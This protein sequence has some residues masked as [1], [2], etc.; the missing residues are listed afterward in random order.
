MTVFSSSRTAVGETGQV[1]IVFKGGAPKQGASQRRV[2]TPLVPLLWEE[3]VPG[4]ERRGENRS[5]WA[6]MGAGGGLPRSTPW[7][8]ARLPG[9]TCL[10]PEPSL[11]SA[12]ATAPLHALGSSPSVLGRK[13]LLTS[14]GKQ[15]TPSA[16]YLPTLGPTLH[17]DP[18]AVG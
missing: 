16:G 18:R 12:A 7:A 2:L 14:S 3:R 15:G 8:P 13:V 17:G 6:E 1:Q 11:V 10:V 5:F 4:P 9:G